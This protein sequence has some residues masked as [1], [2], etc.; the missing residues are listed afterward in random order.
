M[1]IKSLN[2][3]YFGKF[4]HKSFE[5]SDRINIIYGGNEAGKSTVHH[6]IQ[7]MLFGIQ[8]GRG[9]AAAKDDYTRFQP[10]HEGRNYE[11]IIYLEHEGHI[12]RIYRNF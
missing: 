12:Y 11:G 4:H 8:R 7:A 3:E 9:K 6:F 1:I 2:L 10:W 5:L